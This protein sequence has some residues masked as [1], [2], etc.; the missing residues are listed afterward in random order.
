MKKIFNSLLLTLVAALPMF[1]SCSD[2]N[3]SNPTVTQPTEFIIN[4]SPLAE[5]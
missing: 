5:Q 1:T 4:A 3:G 2:D